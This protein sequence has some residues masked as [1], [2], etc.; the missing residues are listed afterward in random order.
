MKYIN[1]KNNFNVKF[2]VKKN[3]LK[4]LLNVIKKIQT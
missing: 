1:K 4:Y 2:R 3:T